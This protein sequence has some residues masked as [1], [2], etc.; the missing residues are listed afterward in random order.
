M[1]D[2]LGSTITITPL[3]ITRDKWGDKTESSGSAVATVGLPYDIFSE[4][5]NF[6]MVGD[7]DEGDTIVIIKYDETVATQASDVRYKL[8]FDSIDYD[9]ISIEDYDISGITLAKQI[10]CKKRI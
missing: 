3:T 5:Y 8:T 7:L 6:Q 2:D 1:I 4:K 10:I 9:V